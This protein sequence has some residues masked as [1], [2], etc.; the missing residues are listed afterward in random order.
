MTDSE[1]P[2]SPAPAP[3]KPASPLAG[4][5]TQANVTLGLSVLAVILAAAPYVV[6]QLQAYQVRNG[7]M[8]QPKILQE[9]SQKF[10]DQQMAETAKALQ[11]GVRTRQASLFGDK[12]DPVLGNPNAPIKVVEFLD[13]NCGY[14]RAATPELKTFLEQNP[15]VQIIVKE[16]P[17]ISQNS[18]ALAAYALASA[19][20]GKYEEMHY[21]LM[22]A[23]IRSDDDMNRVLQKVGLDPDKLHAVAVS[24]DVGNHINRV[25]T[26][27]GDIGIGGTPNF[28]IGTTV[29]DG[30]KIDD[31]KAAVAAE[32]MRLKKG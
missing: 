31:L 12:A 29:I 2:V 14:C 10:R 27:G 3:Q 11:E 5:F 28:V 20:F 24:D 18:R 19:R 4:V 21:A 22:E 30:A 6:P 25:L 32:R 26:L 13:Y 15:D 8:T 9:A 16:Y 17:V 7:L 1:V 23:Q